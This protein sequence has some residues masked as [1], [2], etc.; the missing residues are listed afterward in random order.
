MLFVWEILSV[1]AAPAR[2][3]AALAALKRLRALTPDAISRVPQAKLEAAL[4]A[5]GPYVEQRLSALRAGADIFRRRPALAAVVR[6]PIGAARRAL[7]PLPQLG[8][9]GA[10]RMLLF[11]ADRR[12]MPV[13]TLVHRV[14]RRLGHGGVDKAGRS[15]VRSVRRALSAGLP[16]DLDAYR[17]AFVYL[18]HHGA[19]TC[20]EADPHCKV[21][22]LLEGC[23]DGRLRVQA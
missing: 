10:R 16:C 14:A 12:L 23:P 20:T 15:S 2:R 3:D 13:D 21:C 17:R 8:D 7:K 11:A 6:G 4:A 9:A 18:S 5:A 22:P 1:K 19:S